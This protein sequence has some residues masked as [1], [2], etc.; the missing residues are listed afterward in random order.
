M[1]I[2]QNM[3]ALLDAAAKEAFRV[4]YPY[5]VEVTST[6]TREVTFICTTEAEVSR[7]SI[8]ILPGCRK[9]V[10]FHGVTVEPTH[11]NQ[12][13]SKLL[14][15]YRL[16]VAE[17]YGAKTAMCTVLVG[18]SVEKKILTGYGWTCMTTVT[19]GIEVW[20]KVLRKA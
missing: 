10:V 9:V 6:G 15:G 1:S 8:S 3:T 17:R 11:R 7:F 4:S 18:N 5:H 16:A 12:G 13:L 2:Q 20:T 19:P 14:H